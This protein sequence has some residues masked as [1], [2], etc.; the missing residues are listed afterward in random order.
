[1]TPILSA[2]TVDHWW[3][4][5][6]LTP[7]GGFEATVETRCLPNISAFRAAASGI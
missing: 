1:M 7:P 5:L 6:D 2:L 4:A 3:A